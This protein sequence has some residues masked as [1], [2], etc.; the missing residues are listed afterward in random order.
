MEDCSNA[1]SVVF[2]VAKAR[3]VGIGP[4]VIFNTLTGSGL[5]SN[6]AADTC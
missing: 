3:D 2:E 4:E 1:A 5:D 6:L